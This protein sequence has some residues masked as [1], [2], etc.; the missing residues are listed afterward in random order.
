M[1]LAGLC[2]PAAGSR[3][4]VWV[5]QHL[6]D[7]LVRAGEDLERPSLAA[8]CECSPWER[9]LGFSDANEF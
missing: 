9:E 4:T 8:S 1:V 5:D 7:P 3:D 6:V 2:A